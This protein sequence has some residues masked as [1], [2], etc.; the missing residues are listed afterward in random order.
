M[1]RVGVHNLLMK[2]Q[3]TGTVARRLGSGRPAKVAETIKT[4]MEDQMRLDDETTVSQQQ[5]LLTDH[6]YNISLRTI[7][8]CQTSLGWWKHILPADM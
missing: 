5:K 6:G 3:D 1:S 8:H 7:L 4:I 2:F